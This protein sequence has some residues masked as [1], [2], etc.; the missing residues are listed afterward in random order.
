MAIPY[1]KGNIVKFNGNMHF[2][3]STDTT[4]KS[5]KSGIAKI[6]NIAYER[7]AHPLHII[8]EPWSSA[9]VWGWVSLAD[10]EDINVTDAIDRLAY[11]QIINSPDYWKDIATS[12]KLAYVDKLII[13]S[14]QAID[15]KQSNSL[16]L[17][18]AIDRLITAKIINTP[19]YWQEQASKYNNIACL[20]IKLAESITIPAANANSSNNYFADNNSEEIKMNYIRTAQSYL[21]Y[22]E[23]DGSHQIIIDIYNN[24]G[25]LPMNYRVTYYDAWCATFVSAMAILCGLADTVIPRECSCERQVNLFKQLGTWVEDD[26]YM[27]KAGDIVYYTWDGDEWNE[28][29]NFSDHVGIV[30]N[31]ITEDEILVIEGNKNDQVSYRTIWRNYPYIRGYASPKY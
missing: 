22:N 1:Q 5:C 13:K 4:G 12:G 29:T 21:G 16:N 24:Y 26:N 7:D 2:A 14:C 19:E 17:Q 27:P 28:N 23:W 6:N 18:D 3:S 10:V 30:I 15:T 20:L 31:A 8:A 25:N 9:D 11:L